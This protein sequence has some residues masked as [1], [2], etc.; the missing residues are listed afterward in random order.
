MM[1]GNLMQRYP[2]VQQPGVS[3]AAGAPAGLGM[4]PAQPGGF[5]PQAAQQQQPGNPG[6]ENFLKLLQGL[7]GGTTGSPLNA[8]PGGMQPASPIASAMQTARMPQ[9][10][11]PQGGLW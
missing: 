4:P 9:A 3:N 11:P 1:G 5:A 10:R 6:L 7:G 2:M 8:T